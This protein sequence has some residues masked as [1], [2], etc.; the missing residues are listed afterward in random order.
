MSSMG[1]VLKKIHIE[2][3]RSI[4]DI[5]I[6]LDDNAILFGRNNS[7]KSNFLYAINLVFGR[8]RLEKEDVFFSQTSPYSLEKEVKIE[9]LFLPTDGNGDVCEEFNEKWMETLGMLVG[10]DG[11]EGSQFF[12]ISTTFTYDEDINGY[13]RTRKGISEWS[14]VIR[15][16]VNFIPDK[17][18]EHFDCIYVNAQRDISLDISDRHSFWNNRISRIDIPEE[19]KDEY[20]K[21]VKQLNYTIIDNNPILIDVRENLEE[22]IP[23]G[24][25]TIDLIP[26]D[27]SKIHRGLEIGVIEDGATIPIS[28]MGLGTRSQAVFS[29][30]KTITNANVKDPELSYYCII[31]AE[32]PESHIHPSL[33]KSLAREFDN[34]KAQKIITTHSPFFISESNILNLIC[35]SHNRNGSYYSSLKYCQLSKDEIEPLKKVF[36]ER[37]A[38]ALFSDVIILGEGKTEVYALSSF[39]KAY[40]N[41]TPDQMNVTIVNVDGSTNYKPFLLAC[42]VFNI[43]WLVFSDGEEKTMQDLSKSVNDVFGEDSFKTYK[44]ER[45]IHLLPEGDCYEDYLIRE[46]YSDIIQKTLQEK[47]GD[48][49]MKQMENASNRCPGYTGSELLSRV[50]KIKKNK[51]DYAEPIASALC[52]AE[53]MPS[54]V[55]QLLETVEQML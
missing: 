34:M 40:F 18:M 47:F 38:D 33:Q 19:Q 25:I 51:T 22:V 41:K 48:H 4:N 46:G 52:D 14:D 8:T 6:D 42:R 11:V 17:V 31:L 16:N 2:N 28:N 37:K 20:R 15:Y 3:V 9:L 45:K 5:K 26:E 53:C 24:D 1:I 27:I 39:F 54:I 55:K 12:G 49:F 10:Y 32:E 23:E 35:C 50:I 7:G 44:K 36:I 30:I 29:S 43:K 21:T 13:R